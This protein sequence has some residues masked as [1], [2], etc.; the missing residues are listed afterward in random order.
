MARAKPSSSG[1]APRDLRKPVRW[2]GPEIVNLADSSE[3]ELPSF[4]RRR[5]TSK[6]DND[7]DDDLAETLRRL[8]EKEDVM[9][10]L[11]LRKPLRRFEPDEAEEEEEEEEE[12]IEATRLEF[13][14]VSD[15]DQES[16]DTAEDVEPTPQSAAHGCRPAPVGLYPP[17][18]DPKVDDDDDIASVASRNAR[19]AQDI[20][21]D[22][23]YDPRAS[24]A[25]TDIDELDDDVKSEPGRR[26]GSA[27]GR[28]LEPVT[29]KP[30]CLKPVQCKVDNHWV[31]LFFRFCAERHAMYTRRAA[32]VARHKLTNDETMKAI[33]IG[34][35][36]RQLDPSSANMRNNIIGKGDQSVG[37]VCFRVFLFC[38]FYKDTTWE[39]LCKAVGGIPT[40][41]NFETD[42]PAMEATLHQM[43][44]VEHQ[45]LW[46]GA[47]QIVPPTV[48][49]A[50][51][52][53]NRGKDMAHYAASLRLVLA[54]MKAGI[55]ARLA[56]CT[57]AVDASYVLGTVPTL[58]GF[59]GLN[60]LCFL[61]DTTHFKWRYRDFAT[62][63]PGSR[64]FTQR[65]FGKN[66]INNV[67]ME[68]AG[69]RWLADNQW[70][71]W[72]RLGLDPP[73]EWEN[74]LRPGMRV[75]DVENALCW[76][77]RY[78]NAYVSKGTRSLANKPAP[79]YDAQVTEKCGPPAWCVE[80]KWLGSTSRAPWDG[81]H[82][83][84]DD[85]VGSMGDDIYE[86][87]KVVAR[88][89]QPDDPD[90]LFRVR[91][92]GWMPEWD[93]WERES[94]LRVD[95]EEAL[96]EWLEIERNLRA[97]VEDVKNN[98]PFTWPDGHVIKMENYTPV[99]EVGKQAAGRAARA[100]KR[101]RVKK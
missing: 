60:I 85:H 3:D 88:L 86:I 58:G 52:Y 76:A 63:G 45:R 81:E 7:D 22:D 42:M 70:R 56:K 69:L 66:I 30:L 26:S 83:E 25:S 38:M 80:K 2:P 8:R 96:E 101:A 40:W 13:T 39:A 54:I 43:S 5:S 78:V 27:V 89:G 90:G 49:F 19:S 29:L 44:I 9:H 50:K 18:P 74:G 23:A 31:Y 48:Y 94:S 46:R 55:P 68:E 33:H 71:Y 95:A 32:G 1:A 92:T 28:D 62:C 20:H 11:S 12:E 24:S 97:A 82:A 21:N 34:N 64:K 35:V 84:E 87:E 67:A 16:I 100:A 79:T 91:W 10:E 93:T 14:F 99:R 17:S 41:N 47:F 65:M 73:H 37:E 77:L 72:A 6:G 75:L 57:Y 98:K 36:Y 51:T 4:M 59:L 15:D 53:R 61:N